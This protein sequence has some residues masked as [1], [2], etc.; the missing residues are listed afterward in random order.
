M[1]DAPARRRMPLN[2]RLYHLGAL[3]NGVSAMVILLAA[4]R[5]AEPARHLAVAV[6]VLGM[7]ALFLFLGRAAARS[8]R[9]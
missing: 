7:A 1:N 4:A 9:R 8:A 6:F 5:S 2:A 3:L